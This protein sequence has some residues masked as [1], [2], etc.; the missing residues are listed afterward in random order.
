MTPKQR[1]AAIA[2]IHIGAGQLGI[3]D[4]A[5][6]AMIRQI[7]GAASGS[8][9]D[10]GREGFDA[11]VAH[12]A[13]LGADF[14]RPPRAGKKP[15]G[16]ADRQAMLDK[17]DAYLAEARLPVAYADALARRMYRMERVAWCRPEQLRGIIAAL[18]K[19][20]RKAGRPTA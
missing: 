19:A 15:T 13:R 16:G 5:Y 7:G 11:V 18:D 20:A 3:A 12:L 14:K 1:A 6:R 17:I 9:K 10:L 2:K 8:S 4:E